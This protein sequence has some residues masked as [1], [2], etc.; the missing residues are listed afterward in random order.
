MLFHGLDSFTRPMPGK[1]L[2]K[3]NNYIDTVN[4]RRNIIISR[5][6][7]APGFESQ[8]IRLL[9]KI[10][11]DAY[12]DILLQ[13]PDDYSRYIDVVRNIRDDLEDIFDPN[14]TGIQHRGVFVHQSMGCEEFIFPIQR[15]DLMGQLPMDQGWDA[16]SSVRAVR[17][18]DAD[19]QELSLH[20]THDQLV[21]QK[22]YPTRA[23]IG[24]DVETL[25]LQYVHYCLEHPEIRRLP[26]PVY[27][28][29]YVMIGLLEDLQVLWLRNRYHDV[30][31][32]PIYARSTRIDVNEHIYDNLYGYI[33][34]QY[35]AAMQEVFSLFKTCKRGSVT[36]E[37]VLSSLRTLTYDIASYLKD[38]NTTAQVD[39]GRQT[40]WY[41][42]LRDIR[43]VEFIL[44]LYL[45]QPGFAQTI[46]LIRLLKRDLPL[47][48]N[49]R[50]WQNCKSAK[51]RAFI[52]ADMTRLV[53]R[54]Q[55]L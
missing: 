1:I 37:V 3:L 21:F 17:L 10:L 24:I 25:V 8:G 11:A 39:D 30:L 4:T 9:R 48:M 55:Q 28:H 42:Y 29:R 12:I 33:G 6:T 49:M 5:H 18:L 53:Q 41:E 19:T 40:L 14:S 38:L 54:I 31:T 47:A 22:H 52:E 32:N 51:V 46:N 36:P 20:F 34:T 16:W 7:K 27:L 15:A 23:V 45:L 26:V 44:D 35:P 13:K 50:F 2:P 43:W